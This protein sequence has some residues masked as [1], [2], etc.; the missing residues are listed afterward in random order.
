[1]AKIY[2]KKGDQ[3]E[4]CLVSGEKVL[5]SHVRLESYGT[6]DELNSTIG[7]ALSHMSLSPKKIE[8]AKAL[9]NILFQIQNDLFNIGSQLACADSEMQKKLP[10]ILQQD[11]KKQELKIDELTELL[12]PLKNFILPGGSISS[13]SFHISRTVCRRAERLCLKLRDENNSVDPL[14]IQYLNR[15]SDLLFVIARYCNKVEGFPEIEW[16]KKMSEAK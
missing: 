4:T 1:M 12:P 14:L 9:S 6:L 8:L 2:T 5:K 16:S 11:I 3:G 10:T 13:S 7:V 15:L